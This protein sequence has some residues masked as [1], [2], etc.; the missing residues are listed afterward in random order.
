[1]ADRLRRTPVI[2][3]SGSTA[4]AQMLRSAGVSFTV[5]PARVD[6]AAIRDALAADCSE[7]DP[8]D[9]AEVLARAKAEEVSGRHPDALVIG[10]DQVLAL[11]G[12]IFSKAADATAAARVLRRLKGV[13]HELH[14]AVAIAA[15]GTTDWSIVDTAFMSVRDFSDSF[16]EDY[17]AGAGDALTTCVGCYQLEGLGSQLF[18]DIE[19]DYFTVLGLPLLPLLAELRER[20]VLLV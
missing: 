8:G 1:M 18:E 19:G 10:A 3:A 12:E 2:L 20:K 15:G 5:V 4:R 14:S 17:L 11:E 9:L 7:I 6:E 13:T 16:L